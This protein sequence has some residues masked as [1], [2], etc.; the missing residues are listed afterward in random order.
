MPSR[1]SFIAAFSAPPFPAGALPSAMA[2]RATASVNAARIHSYVF[3][4]PRS[5][6]YVSGMISTFPGAGPAAGRGREA[7]VAAGAHGPDLAD[8]LP[9]YSILRHRASVAA[10]AARR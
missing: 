7:V 8:P 4:L 6:R 3:R 5:M 1:A 10:A 2:H 9:K